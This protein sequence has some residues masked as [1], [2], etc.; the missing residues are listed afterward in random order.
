ME[1]GALAPDVI[2]ILIIDIVEGEIHRIR[3]R[4]DRILLISPDHVEKSGRV[5]DRQGARLTKWSDRQGASHSEEEKSDK[6]D[7]V[8]NL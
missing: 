4:S 5:G 8:W 1:E 7:G 3:E 2:T 6:E